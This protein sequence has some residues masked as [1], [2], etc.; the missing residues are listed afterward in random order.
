MY[1]FDIAEEADDTGKSVSLSVEGKVTASELETLISE[2]A[3]VRANMLPSVS[4]NPPE[5]GD[6]GIE[7]QRIRVQEDVAFSAVLLPDSRL[8]LWLRNIGIGWLIFHLPV[9]KACALR[10]YLVARLPAS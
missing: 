2:L 10:D 5:P 7:K 1:T 6:P 9:S 3:A 4:R 8:C